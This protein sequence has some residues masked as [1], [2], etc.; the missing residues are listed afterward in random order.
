MTKCSAPPKCVNY[1][2]NHPSSSPNCPKF[3]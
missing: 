3:S 2:N 1:N